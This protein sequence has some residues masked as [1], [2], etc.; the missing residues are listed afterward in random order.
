M[1]KSVPNAIADYLEECKPLQPKTHVWYSQKL[2]VFSAWCVAEHVELEDI[3]NRSVTRFQEHLLTTRSPRKNATLS[4]YTVHGYIQVIKGF[5]NWCTQDD[6]YEDHI[7][8]KAIKRVKQV[9]VDEVIIETFTDTQIAALKKA[10]EHEQTQHLRDRDQVMLD[11]LLA[12]G[13]RAN[14][15]CTL[16]LGNVYLHPTDPHIKVFG[17]GRKWREIGLPN[18]TRRKLRRYIDTYRQAAE[19]DE[20]VFISRYHEPLRPKGIDLLFDRLAKWGNIEGVRCSAH[21]CRHTFATNYLRNGGDIYRLSILMG[22]S[23]VKITEIYL[24][25]FRAE[26]ARQRPGEVHR[27]GR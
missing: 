7:S 13:I 19:N 3:N 4:S 26:E 23:S 15:V 18:D 17:K 20:V 24:K 22:H 10:T 1:T 16:T 2:S 9:K 21:T 14:E 8:E 12:T 11:L 6:E 5:A 27:R 25:S